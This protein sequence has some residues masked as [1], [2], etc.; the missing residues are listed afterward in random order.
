MLQLNNKVKEDI[1]TTLYEVCNDIECHLHTQAACEDYR[2][3]LEELSNLVKR[4]T[5]RNTGK[6]PK[7]GKKQRKKKTKKIKLNVQVDAKTLQEDKREKLF[8]I[9]HNISSI[10]TIAGNNV[11]K[12]DFKES[13]IKCLPGNVRKKLKCGKDVALNDV[14]AFNQNV[15]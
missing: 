10:H 14:Y 11:T 9:K 4:Q 15:L 12:I 8:L 3:V 1:A 7:K 6:R 13:K 5:T 2:S